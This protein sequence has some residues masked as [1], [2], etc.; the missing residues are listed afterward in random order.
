MKRKL[1]LLLFLLLVLS[2]F[3]ATPTFLIH[4]FIVLP[5]S[6]LSIKGKTN[7]NTFVCAINSYEG[8]DTLILKEGGLLQ[9]PVFIK[10]KVFLKAKLFDCGMKVMTADFCET[11]QHKK[12][13]NIVIQFYTFQRLPKNL[14]KQDQFKGTIGIALA[15]T[16]KVFEMPCTITPKNTGVIELAGSRQFSFAD[17]NLTP[18]EKMMGMIKTQQEL[19]VTFKLDLKLDTSF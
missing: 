15:G 7:V 14:Q 16:N 10:G 6:T 17:F 11:L 19:N 13:P 12:F 4:K 18:P 9:Q 1:R 8:T 5:T 3:S 2:G